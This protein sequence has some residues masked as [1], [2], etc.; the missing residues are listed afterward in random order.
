MPH[1]PAVN[2]DPLTA[3][4]VES[5]TKIG[6]SHD[7]GPITSSA[8]VCRAEGAIIGSEHVMGDNRKGQHANHT[9]CSN[10]TI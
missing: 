1:L 8:H 10:G 7:T 4:N 9:Q 5:A 3:P 6:M 2:S